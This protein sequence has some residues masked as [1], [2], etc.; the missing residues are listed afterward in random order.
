MYAEK[1]VKKENKT[2]KFAETE[3]FKCQLLR[4]LLRIKLKTTAK[5]FVDI[6][7]GKSKCNMLA[8]V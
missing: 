4:L 1:R 3:L 2:L 5:E 8:F 7:P 6:V